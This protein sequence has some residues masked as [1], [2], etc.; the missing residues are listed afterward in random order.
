MA[1][2]KDTEGRAWQISLNVGTVKRIYRMT[3]VDILDVKDGRLL[4][5]LGDDMC[6][7]ADVL[8]AIVEPQATKR[9]ITDEQF[10][11]AL[12]GDTLHEATEALVSELICFFLQYR[13]RTGRILEALWAKVKEAEER[14]GDL[15]MDKIGSEEMAQA[16]DRQLA[17]ASQ[18]IDQ[19]ISQALGD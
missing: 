19:R 16:I 12:G 11:E 5:E 9:E 14:A 7:L 2:F 8:F 13:P 18:E 6:K 10:G 17:K 3:D 15:A 4:M 1:Q